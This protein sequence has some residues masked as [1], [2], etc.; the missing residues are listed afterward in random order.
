MKN[1]LLLALFSLVISCGPPKLVSTPENAT[2]SND[3]STLEAN[4]DGQTVGADI[5]DFES[6]T[7]RPKTVN[8][9]DER[10]LQEIM[11]YLTSD[12]LKGREAGTEGIELAANFIE[13]RFS[14]SLVKPFYETYRDVLTN[15]SPE[16]FNIVGVVEGT[17][18]ELKNDF[19][20]I[21][22]HY[23][24]IGIV[25]PEN[26]DT[27]AN[28]A[29]DNASGTATVMELARYFGTSKSNKRSLIF[30]LFSAEE[31]G[32]LGSKHLSNR[33]K[34]ENLELYAVLNFEMV[35]VPLK[36]KDYFM[37]VTGYEKSNLAEVSN[38]YS[39]S[40][41]IG[42][43][44]TAKEYNLFQRSDNYPFAQDFNVPSQTYCTFDFTNFNYYHKPGDELSELDLSHMVEVV[45]KTIPVVEGIANGPSGELKLK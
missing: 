32:L 28:G 40:N 29:N 2:I 4:T 14:V 37:Y 42:F 19:I 1:I 43:L 17:D 25:A 9:T 35:G 26:G 45:N 38:K 3:S 39:G 21:G 33:M 31:K 36:G 11:N 10:K 41:L 20:I 30:A 8:F 23:D 5:S 16:S 24:H 15:F 6:T 7:T 44:P 27:I 22:A 18:A 13:D 34:N 12:E